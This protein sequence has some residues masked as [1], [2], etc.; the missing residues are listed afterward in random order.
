MAMAL[1]TP[2]PLAVIVMLC[3]PVATPAPTVTVIDELFCVVGDDPNATVMP[4]GAPA[5]EK[6]TGP[7]KFVRVRFAVDVPVAPW[8][9]GRDAGARPIAMEGG[10]DTVSPTVA[11]R[12]VRPVAVPR[13]VNEAVPADAVA[14]AVMAM[15]PDEDPAAMVIEFAVTPLGRPSTVTVTGPSK[16]PVR[17]MLT[18]MFALPAASMRLPPGP[19]MRGAPASSVRLVGLT[20]IVNAGSG[21]VPPSSSSPPE[22]AARRATGTANR[23]ANRD[24]ERIRIFSP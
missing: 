9:T 23:A 11:V 16:P 7:V 8:A 24:Q 6:V 10:L 17:V 2:V 22:Q 18:V 1:R 14:P 5:A 3:V 4:A 13:T 20:D 15:M 19:A 12:A 21:P